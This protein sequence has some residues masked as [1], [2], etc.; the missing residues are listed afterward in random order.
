MFQTFNLLPRANALHNVEPPL[1]YAGMK[2][3]SGQARQAAPR[4]RR[5]SSE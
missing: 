4:A 2:P 5:G 3:R 1:I